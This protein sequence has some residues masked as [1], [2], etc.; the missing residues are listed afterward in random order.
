MGVCVCVC[1]SWCLCEHVCHSS[2]VQV[3]GQFPEVF[4]SMNSGHKAWWQEP[5]TAVPSVWPLMPFIRDF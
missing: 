5:S 1:V 3:S 4:Q 2:H